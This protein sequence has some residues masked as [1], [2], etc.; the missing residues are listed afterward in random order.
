MFLHIVACS[1]TFVAIVGFAYS[2]H[3]R[4]INF[5]LTVL[6]PILLALQMWIWSEQY[7][8]A[9]SPA[10]LSSSQRYQVAGIAESP[11]ETVVLLVHE[12]GLVSSCRF[13]N[14]VAIGIGAFC[15]VGM[16]SDG[17]YVLMPY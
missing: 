2:F 14:S 17:S 4:S 13:R 9:G 6:L 16:G 7:G 11:A 5:G 12:N 10:A 8:L 3:K 1:G 15:K